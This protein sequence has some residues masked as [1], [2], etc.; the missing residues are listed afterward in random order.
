MTMLRITV[1]HDREAQLDLEDLASR[2]RDAVSI[3]LHLKDAYVDAHHLVFYV[4]PDSGA[5]A[6]ML[7]EQFIQRLGFEPSDTVP[8]D[9]VPIAHD[10]FDAAIRL[11]DDLTDLRPAELVETSAAP[12]DDRTIS[13]TVRHKPHERVDHVDVKERN[14]IVEITAWVGSPR[15]DPRRHYVTIG[16]ALSTITVELEQPLATRRV[17]DAR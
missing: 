16:E 9:A 12:S 2:V 11:A 3:G 13:A 1:R 10:G 15:D 14:D 8:V 4:E 7:I 5:P 6:E 17:V